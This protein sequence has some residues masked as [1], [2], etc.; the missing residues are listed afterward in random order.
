M[1]Q[2]HFAY[3]ENDDYW[4]TI[5]SKGVLDPQSWVESA[6]D[7]VRTLNYLRA[8]AIAFF[9]AVAR[10][11]ALPLEQ[12]VQG[13]YMMIAAF[14]VENLL[15]AIIAKRTLPQDAAQTMGL[16]SELKTHDVVK[17]ADMARVPLTDAGR[18][19]LQRLT[20]F[21]VWAGRYPAPVRV[22]D[23]MPQAIAGLDPNTLNCF[24]GTDIRAIDEILDRC[25]KTLRVQS[26]VGAVDRGYS[27][28]LAVWEQVVMHQ[29][30]KPWEA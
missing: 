23:L 26:L 16:P 15:K 9:T 3:P 7:L 18:D 8:P 5:Y 6:L 28:E 10:G 20:Y 21:A 24:R 4:E 11:H 14:A 1:I 2:L 19:L 22:R 27:G 29:S 12:K 17:L 13:S 25:A 30:V